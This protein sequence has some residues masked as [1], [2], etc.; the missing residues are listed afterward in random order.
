M[1]TDPRP[2]PISEYPRV[3]IEGVSY[4]IRLRWRDAQKLK[5]LHGIDVFD[6]IE[7]LKGFAAMEQTAKILSVAL[8]G[9]VQFTPDQLIDKLDVGDSLAVATAIKNMILKVAPQEN[10]EL[11]PEKS[12]IQ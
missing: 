11:I 7:Q 3:T 4:P 10:P 9:F 6:K 12:S 8:S 1:E 5:E 2:V